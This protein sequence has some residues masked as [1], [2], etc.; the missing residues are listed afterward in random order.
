MN[1]WGGD[2]DKPRVYTHGAV[3][4]RRHPN[5]L[6]SEELRTANGGRRNSIHDLIGRTHNLRREVLSWTL[7]K[8]KL[9]N[10]IPSRSISQT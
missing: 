2:S 10:S 6:E 3:L 9:S 8:F 4:I 5:E 7:F 1:S